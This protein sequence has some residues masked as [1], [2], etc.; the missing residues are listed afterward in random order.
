MDLNRRI[1]GGVTCFGVVCAMPN[2]GLKLGFNP[3]FGCAANLCSG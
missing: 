3:A 2:A 1:S